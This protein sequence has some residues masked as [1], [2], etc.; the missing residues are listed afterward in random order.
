MSLTGVKGVCASVC[1]CVCVFF[2]AFDW[3]SIS[4]VVNL[5]KGG[6]C[7]CVCL[8][9]RSRLHLIGGACRHWSVK[10][11]ACMCVRVY[12]Y[13]HVYTCTLSALF[14]W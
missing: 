9:V 2:V 4:S 5:V 7:M 1:A 11:G 8:R 12:V 13:D 3:W 6:V 14:I 10:G